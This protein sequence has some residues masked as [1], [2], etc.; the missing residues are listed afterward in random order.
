[1]HGVPIRELHVHPGVPADQPQGLHRVPDGAS[2][3]D[4]VADHQQDILLL[5]AQQ[6]GE[7]GHHKKVFRL[8][9]DPGRR[10]PGAHQSVG[11]HDDGLRQGC[12]RH[13]LYRQRGRQVRRLVRLHYTGVQYCDVPGQPPADRLAQQQHHHVTG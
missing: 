3:T 4:D 8:P 12:V 13:L 7:A 2:E 9:G 6:N 5:Q 11:R 10:H 1:M